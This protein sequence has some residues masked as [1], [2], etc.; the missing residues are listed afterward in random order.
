LG[1]DNYRRLA[2]F[3]CQLPIF[4]AVSLNLPPNKSVAGIR[5]P[6]QSRRTGSHTPCRGIY[7]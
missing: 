7:C 5:V 4:K 1:A 3:Q 6:A 2:F